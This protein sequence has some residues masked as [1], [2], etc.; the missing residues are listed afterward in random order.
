MSVE[1]KEPI[2][3]VKPLS[4]WSSQARLIFKLSIP[5]TAGSL[6][7]PLLVLTDGLF[8]AQESEAAY[9]ALSLGSPL[10]ALVLAFA[11]ALGSVGTDRLL[12]ASP[13]SSG[14]I[15]E[16]AVT[17]CLAAGLGMFSLLI[18]ILFAREIHDVFYDIPNL[19]PEIYEHLY[20]Y[21]HVMA[22]SFPISFLLIVSLQLA[23]T[24]K[25]YRFV[26]VMIGLTLGLNLIGTAAAVMWLK[27]G[28]VGAAWATVLSQLTG[29]ALMISWGFKNRDVASGIRM[30]MQQ[31]RSIWPIAAR[32][33]SNAFFVVFG[34]LA[35]AI[36]LVIVSGMA[37][38][39][40]VELIAAYGVSSQLLLLVTSGGRGIVAAMIVVFGQALGQTK[41]D[42]YWPNF[43]AAA[44]VLGLFY[45]V[46]ALLSLTMA[47]FLA[48]LYTNLSEEANRLAVLF[49]QVNAALL[50]VNLLPRVGFTGFLGIGMSPMMLVQGITIVITGYVGAGIGLKQ[51]GPEGFI[52]GMLVGEG[53]AASLMLIVFFILLARRKRID[54]A[55]SCAA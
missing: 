5:L 4:V 31:G 53:T 49:I 45:G 3:V 28:I 37:A 33:V 50:L 1:N 46:A 8:L 13:T 25:R 54:E 42:Y 29:L 20:A 14:R 32:Q 19:P 18:G 34:T 38:A 47:H 10:I 44:W 35:F 51:S 24:V 2:R 39:Y 55:R 11:G 48:S 15:L 6:L 52:I 7:S 30:L 41:T 22:L 36:G 21:W 16:P 26:L 27:L 12:K 17:L 40:S 23:I 43:W 9:A